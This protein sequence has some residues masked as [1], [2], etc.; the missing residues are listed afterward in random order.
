MKKKAAAASGGGG[1]TNGESTDDGYAPSEGET[2]AAVGQREDRP[3]RPRG[4][5]PP[6]SGGGRGRE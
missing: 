2:S 6:R 4:G 5:R 1:E 3:R